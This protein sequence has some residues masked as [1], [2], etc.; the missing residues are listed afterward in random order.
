MAFSCGAAQSASEVPPVSEQPAGAPR[1][2]D[3][4]WEV[5]VNGAAEDV[6]SGE[7]RLTGPAEGC[8]VS[9]VDTDGTHEFRYLRCQLGAHAIETLTGCSLALTHP[10]SASVTLDERIAISNEGNRV[11]L[12]STG[13]KGKVKLFLQCATIETTAP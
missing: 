6:G 5:V 13:P 4:K 3:V 12:N 1:A 7:V 10:V 8:V 11:L 2:A 9:A